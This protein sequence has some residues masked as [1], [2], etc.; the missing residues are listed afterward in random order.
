MLN[1]AQALS[2]ESANRN[3]SRKCNTPAHVELPRSSLA[4]KKASSVSL[5]DIFLT[6]PVMFFGIVSVG[7]GD[8]DR[9]L[10]NTMNII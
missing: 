8:L 5:H 10:T 3:F 2:T 7:L 9:S 4:N 1:G 6:L